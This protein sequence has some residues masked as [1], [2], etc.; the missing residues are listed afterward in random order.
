[1]DGRDCVD[2]GAGRPRPV[3]TL[4][5]SAAFHDSAPAIV[6]DGGLIGAAEEERFTRIEH[7]KRPVPFSAWELPWQTIDHFL[8]AT[9]LARRGRPPRVLLRPER[10]A[11]AAA[12]RHRAACAAPGMQTTACHARHRSRSPRD[13]PCS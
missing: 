12:D 3:I 2:R 10:A 7:G 4:G 11:C 6:R 9:G 8:T 1:L 13:A 5:I